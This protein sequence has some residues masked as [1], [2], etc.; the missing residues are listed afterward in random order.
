MARTSREIIHS[1][2]TKFDLEDRSFGDR[3]QL[4]GS[5]RVQVFLGIVPQTTLGIDL[6]PIVISRNGGKI[7]EE[8]IFVHHYPS[9]RRGAKGRMGLDLI[10]AFEEVEETD[11]RYPL[12]SKVLSEAGL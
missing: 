5:E 9:F 4:K 8:A 7:I 2:Q 12:Y 10:S 3:V 1:Y 6:A 11:R